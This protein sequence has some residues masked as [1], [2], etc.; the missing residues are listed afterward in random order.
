MYIRTACNAHMH[1]WMYVLCVYYPYQCMYLCLVICH[2]FVC[3]HVCIPPFM[4]GYMFFWNGMYISK[5]LNKHV[6]MYLIV[7]IA[8]CLLYALWSFFVESIICV[9]FMVCMMWSVVRK[10]NMTRCNISRK[11]THDIRRKYNIVEYQMIQCSDTV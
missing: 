3:L 10:C 7:C 1:I 4:Y 2:M 8:L 6:C 5:N 9:V 11:I